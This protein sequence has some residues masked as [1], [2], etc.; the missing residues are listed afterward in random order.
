MSAPDGNTNQRDVRD[1]SKWGH[2]FLDL[3]LIS[4]FQLRDIITVLPDFNIKPKRLNYSTNWIIKRKKKKMSDSYES[5]LNFDTVLINRVIMYM[6]TE[7]LLFSSLNRW[8]SSAPRGRG[9][10]FS[11]LT[12][13]FY[14]GGRCDVKE[15]CTGW[16]NLQILKEASF[17]PSSE[18][19][20]FLL[21]VPLLLQSSGCYEKSNL[22]CASSLRAVI[23]DIRQPCKC[24]KMVFG[25][26]ALWEKRLRFHHTIHLLVHSFTVIVLLNCS[27]G[28][29]EKA[30]CVKV[31]VFFFFT[32]LVALCFV[33]SL[34]LLLLIDQNFWHPN[35]WSY[36]Q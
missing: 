26:M 36:L 27:S 4:L 24:K 14:L 8:I 28:R 31:M 11:A 5:A 19:M 7:D 34:E 20:D 33:W 16:G 18:K 17:C 23:Q 6:I 30:L 21:L 29:K 2:G 12:V 1:S 15:S 32:F 25:E 10:A 13:N 3:R 22:I 35:V 9:A